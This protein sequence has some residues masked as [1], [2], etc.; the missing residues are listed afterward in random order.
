MSR[1]QQALFLPSHKGEYVVRETAI[2]KPDA[3]EILIKVKATGLNPVDWKIQRFDSFID[4]YPAILGCEYAGD[5]VEV[6]EG[7]EGFKE[8]DKVFCQADWSN[9]KAAFQQ[10][11]IALAVTTT[12]IPEG[13]SYDYVA[14]IPE[15]LSTAYSA[16]YNSSPHGI[17]LTPPTSH[18]SRQVDAGQPILIMGGATTV[19]QMAIQLAKLSNLSPI[20]V[21][22]SLSNS[23]ALKELGATHVI[24][25]KLAHDEFISQV[26]ATLSGERLKF[27]F[28]AVGDPE[29]QQSAFAALA[30][31]GRLGVVLPSTIPTSEI[32]SSDKSVIFAVAALSMPYNIPLLEDLYGHHL[33]KW[34]AEGAIKPNRVEVIPEGLHGIPAGLKRLETGDVSRLRL[35][36]HPH[37]TTISSTV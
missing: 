20:I 5:V 25:R 16:L 29:T 10:Y 8:A 14:S 33:E 26:S 12:K 28:D 34:V 37:E 32:E 17:G 6:G 1:T 35:V 3:G 22:A 31:G 21:T 9:R 30:S 4:Y 13:F 18:E 27:A 36:I 24:D 2:P 23:E 15:G 7:V 11:A 19:G